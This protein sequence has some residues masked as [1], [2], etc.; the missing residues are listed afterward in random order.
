MYQNQ[1]DLDKIRQLNPV[2]TIHSQPPTHNP[3][4][5]EKQ[6][7]HPHLDH[8]VLRRLGEV[9]LAPRAL[10]VDGEDAQGGD[11]G[12][13]AWLACVRVC[14]ACVFGACVCARFGPAEEA[15]R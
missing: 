8:R 15:L 11:A 1:P 6:P 9:A 10:N 14:G 2:K 13:L 4:P 7:S 5:R 12:P 3:T